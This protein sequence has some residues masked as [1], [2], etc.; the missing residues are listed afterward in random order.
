MIKLKPIVTRIVVLEKV[1]YKLKNLDVE[2]SK[3]ER[4]MTLSLESLTFEVVH[5]CKKKRNRVMKVYKKKDQGHSN[6]NQKG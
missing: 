6:A 4:E 1:A 2:V 5:K 3:I